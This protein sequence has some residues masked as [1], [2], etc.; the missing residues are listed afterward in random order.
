MRFCA[1]QATSTALP[2]PNKK[3]KKKTRINIYRSLEFGVLGLAG[4]C[5][6]GKAGHIIVT[7]K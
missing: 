6:A 2:P 5:S 3:I 7:R 4:A 1:L